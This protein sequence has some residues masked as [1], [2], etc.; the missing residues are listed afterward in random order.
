MATRVMLDPI[1]RI[2]GHLSIRTEV[3]NNHVVEAY[4]SGEMF[5]G[6]ETILRG[7]DPLDAQQITQRICGVCPVPHGLASIL[8]QDQAYGITLTKNGRLLRNLI[9]GANFVQDHILHFYHLSAVDFVD[10][11]AVAKYNGNDNSL[12]ELK[13]WVNSQLNSNILFPAAPFLP[14]YS[15]NYIENDELNFIALKHYLEAMEV[16]KAGTQMVALFAG[17]I[18][19]PAGLIPGGVSEKVTADK[20]A[21]YSARLKKLRTFVDTAY[22][23]D[24]IEVAKVYPEYFDIGKGCG[25]FLA[26]G[27]YPESETDTERFLPGGVLLDNELHALNAAQITED[28]RFSRFSSPSGLNPNVGQSAADPGK[29]DAYTWLKAP[30]YD[31]HVVEVGPLARMMVGY[32]YEQPQ[33]KNIIDDTLTK[34]GLQPRHLVSALGRHLARALETKIIVD[35]CAEWLEQLVPEKPAFVDFEIPQN[36]HGIGLWEAPRGALGHWLNIKDYKI[37]NYQCVVPTT[38]NCS[39]RDDQGKPGPVEQALVGTRIEDEQNPIEAARVVRSFDPCLACAV[40]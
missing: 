37:S 1:T 8:A 28:T 18:P 30:R 16:R 21:A 26:Y 17:K 15:G 29:Q 38:W 23:P 20:I 7:R 12:N 14:R 35:R 34:T 36:S 32:H 31:G 40:H 3:E 2:E 25:N 27:I 9:S 19:H 24:V 4:C 5:R 10:V 33:I 39:P 11:A 6:F 22:L 13:A